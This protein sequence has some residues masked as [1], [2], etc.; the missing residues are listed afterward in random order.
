M[1]RIKNLLY[2]LTIK[3]YILKEEHTA[4]GS[5]VVQLVNDKTTIEKQF[6]QRS[7]ICRFIVKTLTAEAQ[8]TAVKEETKKPSPHNMLVN[9]SVIELMHRFTRSVNELSFDSNREVTLDQFE[10]ALLYLSKT[11][12]L[13]LE[14]GF[15]VIYNTLQLDR[16]A[17]RGA[18]YGKEQYRMLDEFYKQRIRQIHIVGEYANLM[19]KDYDAAL[20]FVNDYFNMDFR[21][22]IQKY[23]KGERKTEINNNITP[24]K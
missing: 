8:R 14:G 20:Q 22:F 11:S 18:R 15:L 3:N 12:L 16:V 23:F 6:E 17:D 10:E 5:A 13:K 9:F 1:K 21:K 4:T 24:D 19:V 7:Q 2:F